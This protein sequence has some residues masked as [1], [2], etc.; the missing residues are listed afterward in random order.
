MNALNMKNEFGSLN[1][2]DIIQY[3]KL[4]F[5]DCDIEMLLDITQ[6]LNIKLNKEAK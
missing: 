1:L 3:Y 6:S 2:N 4:Y 5:K